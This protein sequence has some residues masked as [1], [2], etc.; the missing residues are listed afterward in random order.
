MKFNKILSQSQ[1]VVW[2]GPM[3]VF[4]IKGFAKGT[5]EIGIHLANCVEEGHKVIIGGGDTAAATERFGLSRMMTHVSTGGGASLELLS[6]QR[7]PALEA[8]EL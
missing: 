6:G 1:T 2:N 3:G 8:L 7:L 5:R 4:E